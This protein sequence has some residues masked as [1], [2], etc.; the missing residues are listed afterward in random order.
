MKQR[1]TISKS[2][3]RVALLTAVGLSA[4]FL[5]AAC[6]GVEGAAGL[7][8]PRGAQGPAGPAGPAGEPGAGIDPAVREFTVTLT[9]GRVVQE[10]DGNRSVIGNFWN[11]QPN[12]LVAFRGDTISLTVVNP[13]DEAHS[14]RFPDLEGLQTDRLAKDESAEL[15]FEA[16]QAG[17]FAFRCGLRPNAEQ[18]DCTPDH[19]RQVGYLIVLDR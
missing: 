9:D 3:R 16:A 11:W 17:V 2:A 8:G 7:E 1:M 5:L 10:V 14:L 18:G 13:N 12:I 19:G 4:V 15:T 6:A